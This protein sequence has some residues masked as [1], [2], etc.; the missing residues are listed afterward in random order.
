MKIFLEFP[1]SVKD[2][3]P[4]LP[5]FIEGPVAPRVGE[6]FACDVKEN[7]DSNSAEETFF[8]IDTV[9][10]DFQGGQM[11]VILVLSETDAVSIR[12]IGS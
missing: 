4:T 9:C 5:R 3:N 8:R 7:F 12:E 10:Y 1:H 2:A 6:H 11:E